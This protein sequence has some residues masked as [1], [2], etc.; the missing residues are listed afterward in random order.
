[1]TQE[2]KATRYDGAI[3]KAKK[4][5]N[6][7]GSQDCD[8]ARQI[9]R[10]FPELKDEDE[11]IRKNIIATI[12]LYYGEPLE[13]EAK[14]MIAWLEKQGEQTNLPQFTFDDIL[15]LQC[16]METVKKVQ[17]DNELYEQLNLLHSK[18]Y[19]AYQLKKQGEQKP[20][21]KVEPKFKVGDIVQY[22]T[23]STDRRRI[24]DVDELCNMYHT[25]SSPIMF[26]VEG[27]WKVVVHAEDVEDDS[28]EFEKKELKKIEQNPAWSEEDESYLNTTIAYLRDAKEFKKMAENCIDWLKSIKDRVLPQPKQEWSEED[29]KN[30]K[31]AIKVLKVTNFHHTADM[32][33]E[34]KY[35]LISSEKNQLETE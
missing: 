20:A 24:E 27:E 26:E 17:E 18:V 10:L 9:F 23:D 12:H 11:R 30:F 13:D 16:C 14:E 7:C 31:K 28:T 6:T 33:Q 2:E 29:E 15:A 35:K 4:E 1:M 19:D 3:E 8:A 25:S 22:I 5:L 21:D 32:L 34:M